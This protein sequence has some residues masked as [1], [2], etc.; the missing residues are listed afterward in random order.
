[1]EHYLDYLKQLMPADYLKEAEL[2]FNHNISGYESIM[3]TSSANKYRKPV[4]NMFARIKTTGKNPYI[5]FKDKYISKFKNIGFEVYQIKSDTGY[6]RIPL[7]SFF[8]QDLFLQLHIE[9]IKQLLSSIFVDTLNFDSFGCCSLYEECSNSKK[10]LH[11]DILYSTACMYRKNLE[12]GKIFY[13]KN[14]NI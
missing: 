4:N 9:E 3:I 2:T 11:E 5:S 14:K 10:C 7:N 6:F 12:N 8:T 1:M 13:G